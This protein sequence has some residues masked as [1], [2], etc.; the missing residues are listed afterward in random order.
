M[1][2]EQLQVDMRFIHFYGDYNLGKRDTAGAC[3]NFNILD[4][5]DI[6]DDC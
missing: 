2:Q 1:R 3:L 6:T 5:K 4:K